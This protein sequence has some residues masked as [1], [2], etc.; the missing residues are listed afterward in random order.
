M[1]APSTYVKNA[2]HGALSLSDG[3]GTP[4]TLTVSYDKGDL[5]LNGLG[6]VLN[7]LVHIS[8]R[9]KYVSSAHGAR[10]YPTV[11]F[12]MFATNVVGSSSSAPGSVTEFLTGKGAYSANIST[13]GSGRPMAVKLTLTIEGSNFGDTAD[14]TIVMNNVLVETINFN[15]AEDGNTISFEGTVLG[16]VVVT[17]STNIVTYSEV[18]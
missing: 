8:R 10:R 18:A 1:A 12:S 14:E 11:S 13:L 16:S 2:I 9:G 7:D 5:Q 4:V 6:A 17:N 3:T 15:E